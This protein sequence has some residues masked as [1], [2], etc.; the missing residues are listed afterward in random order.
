MNTSL[1]NCL[2]MSSLV[3]AYL[4]EIR[5]PAS[6]ANNG[7]DCVLILERKHE[8]KLKGLSEWFLRMGFNMKVEE[9]VYDLR[10]VSFCQVN[11]LTS[12]NYNI[13]VRNP[14]VVLSKDLHSTY[15]FTHENQY[16][17]WLTASGICGSTSHGGVPVLE[18]FY[19]CFPTGEITNRGV[20]ATL[21]NWQKYSIV[22]GGMDIHISDEMRHSFWV[23]FGILPD[24]QIALEHVL[25]GVRFGTTI[26][27][28]GGFPYSSIFQGNI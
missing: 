26:G 27:K 17:Q 4:R 11:V 24:A 8:H 20:V 22:G 13:C 16:L 28:I 14:H 3:H 7:D 21:E 23:A 10:Q 18:Q 19:K 1:G 12:P 15:P 9:P 6:L 5:V 2:L 25:L